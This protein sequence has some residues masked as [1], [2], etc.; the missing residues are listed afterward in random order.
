MI[1]R[2]VCVPILTGLISSTATAAPVG[3]LKAT[4][5]WRLDYAATQC[6]AAREYGE[7][8]DPIGF[9]IRPAPNGS[10]YELLVG[11][12]RKGPGFAE[13]LEGSVDFGTGPIKAWVLHYGAKKSKVAVHQFRI[14]ASAMAQ[15]R[16]ASAIALHMKG[17]PDLM[18]ELNSMPA[19]LKGL[20]ECTENLRHYWN[21]DPAGASRIATFAKG[22]VRSVFSSTDYPWEALTRRQQGTVQFLLLIDEKGQVAACHVL[23]ASGVPALDAMGCQVIQTRARF[24]PA[25]D[26]AGKPIRSSYV[27][28]PVMWRMM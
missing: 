12:K 17:G 9:A 26:S 10:S 27:T 28:P 23:S 20:D 16:N 19:L 1:A 18:F 25:L 21:S 4:E 7:S 6:T 22:D 2:F 5:P 8:A 11:R 15:A 24:K 3:P 14:D 13:E